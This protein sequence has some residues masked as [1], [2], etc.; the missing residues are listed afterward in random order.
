MF[1]IKSFCCIVLAVEFLLIVKQF[2]ARKSIV[3][4][5]QEKCNKTFQELIPDIQKIIV[6][7]SYADM[8]NQETEYDMSC[9]GESTLTYATNLST[10]LLRKL[11]K[12]EKNIEGEGYFFDAIFWYKI[13]NFLSLHVTKQE[14]N[15]YTRT[16]FFSVP[17][18]SHMMIDG[19]NKDNYIIVAC[20]NH[21]DSALFLTRINQ[22][23]YGWGHGDCM[24]YEKKF[25][26]FKGTNNSITTIMMHPTK[27]T[28]AYANTKIID[29]ITVQQEIHIVE[30]AYTEKPS[31]FHSL[32][33]NNNGNNEFKKIPIDYHVSVNCEIKKITFFGG[34]SYMFLTSSG[35]LGMCWLTKD[36]D[37][38]TVVEWQIKKHTSF[39][40]D[41]EPDITT[42]TKNGYLLN[43]AFLNDKREIY[44]CNF[45][46]PLNQSTLFFV[47]QADL[48]SEDEFIDRLYFNN[49]R[50]GVLYKNIDNTRPIS[51][52]RLIMYE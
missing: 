34:N 15:K 47:K 49:Q 11:K 24:H 21:I 18:N 50:C 14:G 45:S 31:F 32:I 44:V 46:I 6:K 3:I 22:H 13:S 35:Q 1:L 43:W 27:N 12:I 7:K 30:N 39:F 48:S 19:P 2:I 4:L 28:I 51:Y 16:K 52:T 20:S 42:K 37:G 8:Y 23:S 17:N 25:K 40:I 29:S 33:E 26:P 9:E 38:Q 36:K 5:N 10:R 41:C